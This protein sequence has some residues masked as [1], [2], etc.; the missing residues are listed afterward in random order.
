MY[1]GLLYFSAMAN[2]NLISSKQTGSVAGVDS[3]G[4][5]RATHGARNLTPFCVYEGV[6]RDIDMNQKTLTVDV[7]GIQ[8]SECRLM[9][10]AFA[11]Y[12][13]VSN[14]AMP[15]VGSNVLVAHFFT[16]N[17]VF[18]CQPLVVEDNEVWDPP[19]T[20]DKDFNALDQSKAFQ[21]EALTDNAQMSPGYKL[22]IDMVPGEWQQTSGIGSVIRLLSNFAQ[23]SAGDLAKIE[24]HLMNDMVRIVDNY[25]AHHN[26][27]G[28]TLIWS[29]GRC[30][31]EEHFTSYPHEAEGKK[32][33][34]G[35]A[36]GEKIEEGVYDPISKLPESTANSTGR[37]RKSTYVGFL[38]DMIHHFVTLPPEDETT[39]SVS[40]DRTGQFRQWIGADGTLCIQAAGGVHIEMTN[41]IVVPTILTAWNDPDFDAEDA[42]KNLEQDFLSLWGNGPDWDD[43]KTACW[44]MRTYLRYI[45]LWH[46]LAR[47][48]QAEEKNYCI[49]PNED[50]IGLSDPTCD[51]EDKKK[52]NQE[53][54]PYKGHSILMMDPSGSMSFVSNGNT[55]VILN[56][57]NIQVSCPGNIELKAGGTVAIQGRDVSVRGANRVEILSMFGSLMTKARTLWQALCEKGHIWIKGDAQEGD[58]GYKDGNISGDD[59]EKSIMKKYAVVID[60]SRGKTLVHGAKGAVLGSTEPSSDV[61]VQAM[62]S[63]SSVKVHAA[64]EF[65]CY[66]RIR[67]KMHSA[68]VGI[69]ADASLKL[70]SYDIKVGDTCRIVPGTHIFSGNIMTDMIYSKGG[71]QADELNHYVMGSEEPIEVDAD[72]ESADQIGEEAIK[73]GEKETRTNYPK[74][75]LQQ[76][77]WKLPKWKPET[78]IEKWGSLKASMYEDATQ[79]KGTGPFDVVNW[80][81]TKLLGAP[82]TDTSNPPFP[83]S[84]AKLFMFNDKKTSVLVETFKGEFKKEDIKKQSDM[85][86]E[87]YKGFFIKPG[88]ST[89]LTEN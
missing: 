46:A 48:K 72:S 13:G 69:A 61:H 39:Y 71:I 45:P 2:E 33:P 32:K 70:Q 42:I 34:T 64:N 5:S 40:A 88:E 75:E 84:G 89:S 14:V 9:A 49:V 27:G 50:D 54:G 36:L 68:L 38:G 41:R 77:K 51:E 87:A 18:G 74:E 12:I 81:S 23:M 26:V 63:A 10:N 28:D 8:L 73:L 62:G 52:A 7:L 43:L 76:Y 53:A 21:R 66:A 44:Q 55:S 16:T 83:G 67:T 78:S 47:F 79:I 59:V 25:F 19:V 24:V 60:A 37:W 20:G 1:L 4:T 35:E 58:D 85:K 31:Y 65:D 29:N 11:S 56:E 57:G 82:R 15:L 30:N 3:E 80:N 22:P 17:Y 86:A 6:V